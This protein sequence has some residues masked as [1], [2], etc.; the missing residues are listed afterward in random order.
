MLPIARLD[1]SPLIIVYLAK[2]TIL[3]V[4]VERKGD[5]GDREHMIRYVCDVMTQKRHTDSREWSDVVQE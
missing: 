1:Q 3:Y 2:K 4:K 5:H